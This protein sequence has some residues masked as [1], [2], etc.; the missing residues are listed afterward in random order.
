MKTP[1][2]PG[3]TLSVIVLLAM[4]I[5]AIGPVSVAVAQDRA[6]DNDYWWPDRLSLEPLRRT[7]P[8]SSPLGADFDYREAFESVDLAAL[9]ADLDA[10]MTLD[11]F[12]LLD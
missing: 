7:S 9:K 11:R 6:P 12:D 4:G 10:V 3:R 8:G 2:T 5:V 1:P